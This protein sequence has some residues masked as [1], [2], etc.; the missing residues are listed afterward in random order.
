M[1]DFT[2]LLIIATFLT[3]IISLLSYLNYSK[4]S[5][6]GF[7]DLCKSIFPILF[8]VLFIRSFIVEPYRIPSGSMIPTLLVGDFILVKKYQYGIKMPLSNQ[9]LIENR[10]PQ[11]GDIIVFQYPLNKEINY[12]K[13]VIALPGDRIDYINKQVF[14]NGKKVSHLNI[15]SHMIS[16]QDIGSG[17]I[18]KE[19]L[20]KNTHIILVDK[21]NSG[22][23]FSY[24]VPKNSYFVLGDNR[25]NSNDSRYWGAVHEDHIIGEA[26]LIWMFW[27]PDSEYS[28]SDRIGTSLN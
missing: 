21:L 19:K 20:F 4:D 10:K 14:I 8:I 1:F 17:K 5:L 9:L 22:Q 24:T 11:Y 3:G 15:S 6:Q 16:E 28:L 2:L 18:I 26:F 23:D 13:R 12:I 27:N 7:N 25:D